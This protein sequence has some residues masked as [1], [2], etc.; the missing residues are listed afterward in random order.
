MIPLEKQIEAV[1]FAARQA[2]NM[3]WTSAAAKR[4]ADEL[5]EACDTL[6]RV[7]LANEDQELRSGRE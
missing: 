5:R 1:D 3:A 7:K 6:R 4:Y 2:S